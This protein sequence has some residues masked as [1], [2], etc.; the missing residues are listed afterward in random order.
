MMENVGKLKTT[1][2]ISLPISLQFHFTKKKLE[3][4]LL[5]EVQ[6]HV[7]LSFL[8]DYKFV[9]LAGPSKTVG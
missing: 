3:K 4:K 1:P 7:K 2:F 9:I 6:F 8:D 5:L